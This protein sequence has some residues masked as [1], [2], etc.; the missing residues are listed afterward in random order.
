[1]RLNFTTR[2]WLWLCVVMALAFGWGSH[3][4]Y[5]EWVE[6]NVVNSPPTVIADHT[7]MHDRDLAIERLSHMR[8]DYDSLIYG[9]VKVLSPE[10]RKEL[11]KWRESYRK[12]GESSLE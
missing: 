8:N 4:R 9:I 5:S 2:D 3:F 12:S 10:Q 1:V 6:E 7:L 11:E